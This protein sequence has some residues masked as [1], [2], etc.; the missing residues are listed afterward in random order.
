MRTVAIVS[1][2]ISMSFA[3]TAFAQSEGIQATVASEVIA[4]RETRPIEMNTAAKVV[5]AEGNVSIVDAVNQSNEV[6]VGDVIS[7]GDLL[8]TGNDGELHLQMDDGGYIALRPNTK[9]RFT[10]YQARG[11]DSDNSIIS[12]FHGSLRA[13]SGWIGKFNQPKYAITTPTATIGLRGT[14]HEPMVI[15]QGAT[16]TDAEPG[17]YDK[18]NVGS[19]TITSSAGMTE[20][21]SG[22]A[23]FAGHDRNVPRLLKD[24]PTFYRVHRNEKLLNGKH[25]A[26]QQ[27][28][29]ELRDARRVANE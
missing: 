6:K 20:I 13:I 17:T 15:P 24:T 29:V 10:S 18:V 12:L 5:L 4:P 2:L 25:D 21:M 28:I 11:L 27:V 7:E 16:D 22:Q 3:L 9:M 19:S 1:Y 8:I 26:I 14:D 23:G